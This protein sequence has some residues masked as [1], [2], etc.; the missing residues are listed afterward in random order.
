MKTSDDLITLTGI[1][2]FQ[3]YKLKEMGVIPKPRVI[4]RRGK[5]HR[6]TVG[7][8][9]DDVALILGWVKKQ[10][11]EGYSLPEI[12]RIWR[13]GRAEEQGV[14]ATQRKSSWGVSMF[15]ELEKRLEREGREAVSGEVE[16]LEEKPDGTVIGQFK[17]VTIPKHTEG[18]L[19]K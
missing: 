7:A 10:L 5:G 3:L 14:L 15:K 9:D 19:G 18:K 11:E 12:A 17:V 4:N 6:G 8:Y 1:T 16:L 2:Q 13:E